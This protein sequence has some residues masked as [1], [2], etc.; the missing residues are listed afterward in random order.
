MGNRKAA[1]EAVYGYLEQHLSRKEM[2]AVDAK[3]ISAPFVD[4]MLLNFQKYDPVTKREMTK[5]YTIRTTNPYLYIAGRRPR[6]FFVESEEEKKKK[7]DEKK[8]KRARRRLWGDGPRGGAEVDF[9][10]WSSNNGGANKY[11]VLPS[12][13]S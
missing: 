8:K 7:K 11:L 13:S 6:R 5:A 2:A 1:S 4:K 3:L 10:R 9:L 12:K